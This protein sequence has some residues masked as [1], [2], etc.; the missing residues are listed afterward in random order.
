MVKV[1]EV[2]DS[3]QQKTLRGHD[4]PVL[5]VSFDPKDE[6]L[7]GSRIHIGCYTGSRSVRLDIF[8]KTSTLILFIS[9][10]HGLVRINLFKT[11]LDTCGVP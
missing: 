9:F 3:S 10:K 2:A 7:V 11:V 1:V 5:S 6:F 4:A 8:T